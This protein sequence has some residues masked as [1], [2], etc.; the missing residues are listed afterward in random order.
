MNGTEAIP[1]SRNCGSIMVP[2]HRTVTGATG[3]A[4]HCKV[5]KM[6]IAES[7]PEKAGGG[8]SIPSLA[9]IFNHLHTLSFPW[10]HYGHK[11]IGPLGLLIAANCSPKA[12]YSCGETILCNSG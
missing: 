1:A 9:T 4:K 8:G 5:N 2:I 12:L 3:R 10:S 7:S 6:T 11:I